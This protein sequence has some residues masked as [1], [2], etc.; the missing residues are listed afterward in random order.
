MV[1]PETGLVALGS[2]TSPGGPRGFGAWHRA[3]AAVPGGSRSRCSDGPRGRSEL[4]GEA[5]RKHL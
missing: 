5:A 3:D 4:S 1:C 2:H